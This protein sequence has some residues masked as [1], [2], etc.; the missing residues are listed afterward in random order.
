MR[1]FSNKNCRENKNTHFTFSNVFP[2]IVPFMTMSKN[3]VKPERPQI[4]TWRRVACWIVKATWAQA[5]VRVRTPTP[6]QHPPPPP[7][8]T[9]ICNTHCSST[10]AMVSW[11]H[12]NV[13]FYAHCVSCFF[14]WSGEI[15]SM[16]N[17]PFSLGLGTSWESKTKAW[18]FDDLIHTACNNKICMSFKIDKVSH[19][20]E[21][22]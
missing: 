4:T 19:Q 17:T 3:L 5:H 22:E 9:E 20:T 2:K 7:T 14:F 12:L 11:T 18:S 13:T 8:H 15:S 21:Y 6:T 10:D 16:S 1:K